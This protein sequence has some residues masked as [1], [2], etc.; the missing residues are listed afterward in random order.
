[1]TIGELSREIEKNLKI[2]RPPRIQKTLT[3]KMIMDAYRMLMRPDPYAH[4][5]W[6]EQMPERDQKIWL[7][8]EAAYYRQ[9]EWIRRGRFAEAATILFALLLG[10]WLAV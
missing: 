3:K 4:L 2:N 8:L 6:F 9:Q 1:M 10:I 7:R 5:S